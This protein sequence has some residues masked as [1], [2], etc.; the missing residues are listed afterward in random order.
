MGKASSMAEKLLEYITKKEQQLVEITM[1]SKEI[2]YLGKKENTSAIASFKISILEELKRNKQNR[3][4]SDSSRH[5]NPLNQSLKSKPNSSTG[6][7]KEDLRMI[8]LKNSHVKKKLQQSQIT[9]REPTKRA[10]D[11]NHIDSPNNSSGILKEINAIVSANPPELA[12][13]FDIMSNEMNWENIQFYENPWRSQSPTCAQ[14]KLLDIILEEEKFEKQVDE[15]KMDKLRY[16]FQDELMQSHFFEEDPRKNTSCIL[17][18][19]ISLPLQKGGALR[20]VNSLDLISVTNLDS[21]INR[22]KT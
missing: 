4:G 20:R 1:L 10:S 19:I 16:S 22:Q 8:A 13:N 9:K 17:D 5:I 2:K 6:K 11:V 12:H 15:W 21:P 18:G 14:N 3:R 7:S